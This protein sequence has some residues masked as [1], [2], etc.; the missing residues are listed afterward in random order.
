MVYNV[1]IIKQTTSKEENNMKCQEYFYSEEEAQNFMKA[2][3]Y[4]GADAELI[5]TEDED[6]GDMVYIVNYNPPKYNK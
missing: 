5:K 1:I 3:N 4:D 2:I 6:T